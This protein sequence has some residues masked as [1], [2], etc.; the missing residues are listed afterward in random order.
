MNDLI[1]V[2]I[3]VHNVEKY[4]KD[5]LVSLSKQTY[6][7]FEAILV[8]NNSSDASEDIC[9]KFATKD[10]RFK[11]TAIDEGGIS[12][13][14]NVGLAQAEGDYIAFVDSDDI[15]HPN[16]LSSLY[17]VIIE[18]DADISVCNYINIPDESIYK[19]LSF[20]K[21]SN[22][23]ATHYSSRDI[24]YLYFLKHDTKYVTV[25]N[26]L[27]KKDLF[28]DIS[29]PIGKKS[30]DEYVSYR[31]LYKSKQTA[32]FSENLY[33]YR[34]RPGSI[35]HT[36]SGTRY[37]DALQA[38]SNRTDFFREN[39]ELQLAQLSAGQTLHW[40]VVFYYN[41]CSSD[42]FS[43]ITIKQIFDKEYDF[44][45]N[46]NHSLSKSQVDLFSKFYFNPVKAHATYRVIEHRN[47][48][49]KTALPTVVKN[50]LR[51]IKKDFKYNIKTKLTLTKIKLKSP[52]SIM[53]IED[54]LDAVCSMSKG[55][56]RFGDGE[57]S[58]MTGGN[59]GFHKADAKLA[60]RL[61]Q[62]I[63]D[64]D[65]PCYIGIPDEINFLDYERQTEKSQRYW[66][67][68]IHN[69]RKTWHKFLNPEIDYLTT[70]V[71][72]P[73]MRFF[74][75]SSSIEYFKQLRTLWDNKDI[76]IIEGEY[77]RLGVGNDLFAKSNIKR[78]ICPATNAF[79]KYADIL[80]EAKKLDKNTPIFIALGPCATVLAY[81][82][83]KEG[84]IAFDIGHCDIEYEWMLA[85][86]DSKIPLP[87]KY[88]NEADNGDKK[89]SC[90][91]TQYFS[92]ILVTIS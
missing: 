11:V 8:V 57:L 65:A 5:C 29:F 28:D 35:M 91:D 89:L 43:A 70:N 77:S 76:I 86:T 75:K 12:I 10:S 84:Y 30:E 66:M 92:E 9:N 80:A 49:K 19:N 64:K 32:I 38:Y 60:Q 34:Q 58:I 24:M 1:S 67:W 44:L 26:K 85:R 54:S 15:V 18:N 17:N 13:A 48:L 25:W 45:I 73:Y 37:T 90:E 51:N 6:D 71:S 79:D 46:T 87:G 3:P 88:V 74:D 72:R 27:Y 50:E 22:L 41:I 52:I 56:C 40:S 62:I 14:R 4:I 61:R 20:E 69:E 7:N 39:N 82:L 63:S 68:H 53:S 21:N 47:Y 42:A 2:I 16:Y 31:L 33:L 81:D 36:F 55:L 78:I 59:I 23:S 83:C